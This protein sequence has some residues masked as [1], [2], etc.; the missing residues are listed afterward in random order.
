MG[1]FMFYMRKLCY[2]LL[3]LNLTTVYSQN[4]LNELDKLYK[5][6]RRTYE[7][8]TDSALIYIKKANVIAS[9][10]NDE[11]WMAKTNY[12]LGYCYYLKGQD[13]ISLSYMQKAI[14]Y[15]EKSNNDDVL[16]KAYNQK[17][18]FYSYKNEYKK[19]LELF[20]KSLKISKNN[21]Q[22]TDNTVS[23]LSNIADIHI[24]Q[25]DTIT[26]LNYYYKAKS[27]GEKNNS[28]R[29]NSVYNNLGTLYVINKKDSALFYFYKSLKKDEENNNLYGQI[30]T[31]IN[32]ANTYLN[33]NSLKDYP[34]AL[35]K[36]KK[37]SD[38]AN[39]LNNSESLFFSNFFL[40]SYYE[41]VERNNEKA[42]SYYKES[43]KLI[44]K[45]YKSEYTVQLY[46]SLSR[47]A[48]KL[49]D[50][51]TAYEYQVKF[52]TLQ[53]SVFSVEKNKQFHEIQTKFD[54]QQKNSS[55]QLLNKENEIQSK[56]KLL[57][58]ISASVLVLF[59]M[60][61]AYIYKKEAKSQKVIRKQDLLLFQKERETTKHQ[62][63]LSEIKYLIAGQNK[64]RSRLS[65]EL[66]DGIGSSVAAIKMNLAM[67][68]Q[69]DIKNSKLD[70]Q[71]EQLDN[72]SK[73]IRIIS[74]SLSIGIDSEKSLLEL[75]NDLIEINQFD[76]KFQMQMSVFPE[77]CLDDLED[78]FKINI[79]RIFQEAFTNISKHSQAQNV[80][81]NCTYHDN[82]LTMIIE[83]DGIGFEPHSP[84]GIGIKNIKERTEEL[85]GSIHID[86]A[87]NH[88]TTISIHL[89]KLPLNENK[90]RIS[91]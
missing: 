54:V 35:H 3:L 48:R 20:H 5:D 74:H 24:W 84:Q 56:Q 87:I 58:F 53:D 65:K 26:G 40:G 8:Q 59:F 6:Y 61:I 17:G 39:Q 27:I 50:Y 70:L 60:I 51:K 89:P 91:R 69:N 29:L 37:A 45:G 31:N 14:N 22:L 82:E 4:Q 25:Q 62:K 41:K 7:N 10:N 28:I 13:S 16:S 11:N 85:K 15:A 77:N 83:D 66:H 32:I 57:I 64:E 55:I 81:I 34:E 9:K 68:N 73:E 23:V 67:L 79:Y 18:L 88:G 12:G 86:S 19:A 33:F 49:G 42:E 78:F 2:L 71:I 72:L 63:K 90:N 21:N 30:N 80:E 52:Q 44:K 43:L 47:V 36:L 76:R 38:L 1:F 75:I 46:K